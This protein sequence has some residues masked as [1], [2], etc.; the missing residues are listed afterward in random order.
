M[1]SRW[2]FPSIKTLHFRIPSFQLVFFTVIAAVFFLYGILYYFSAMLLVSCV[3]YIVLAA[4]LSIIR[5]I[6]GKKSATLVD[7]EPD[8][9]A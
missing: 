5:L 2:K 4:I 6:A 3:G 1:I 7:F 8:D 9:E